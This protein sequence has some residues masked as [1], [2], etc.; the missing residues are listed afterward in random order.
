MLKLPA[1]RD[2]AAKQYP[3]RGVQ[4][5]DEVAAAM[6]WLLSPNSA[7]LTGQVLAADGG[8]STVR[9]LVR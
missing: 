6:D 2:G 5:A 7:R 8:F 4:T 3:L 1:M 9:P